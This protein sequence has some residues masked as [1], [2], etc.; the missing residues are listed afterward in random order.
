MFRQLLNK[1]NIQV[2]TIIR[3]T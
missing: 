1:T 2:M 3:H